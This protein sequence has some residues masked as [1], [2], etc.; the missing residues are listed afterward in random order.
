MRTTAAAV[1]D[2]V[3][4]MKLGIIGCL[5]GSAAAMLFSGCATDPNVAAD[6]PR[7]TYRGAYRTAF[8]TD[9]DERFAVE[10]STPVFVE[11]R[12]VVVDNRSMQV[13]IYRTGDEYFYTYGGRRFAVAG[14]PVVRQTVGRRAAR[15][16]AYRSA[17]Q[18]E[19]PL[20]RTGYTED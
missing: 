6:S 20:I 8:T 10:A 2:S 9:A 14:T 1:Y 3:S 17:L 4:A 18:E 16:A 12:T 19:H 13:P 5:T 11:Q 7:D 15:R